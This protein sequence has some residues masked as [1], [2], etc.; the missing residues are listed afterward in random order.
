MKNE[1]I[2]HKRRNFFLCLLWLTFCSFPSPLFAAGS[3]LVGRVTDP[4]GKS[5][6]NA[7]VHVQTE[8]G[9]MI[10][11]MTDNRGG[12][13]IEISGTFQIEIGHE[14]FRTIR[15]SAVSLTGESDDVYQVE[16][17]LRLGEPKDVEKV[18]LQIEEVANLEN[19]GEPTVREGLP[20]SDRL[21]GLRGGVNVTKIAE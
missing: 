15:S 3:V 6:S 12:F 20:K 14:G 8:T 4:Q 19:R 9:R 18:L 11:L 21:F 10:D 7:A 5:I 16:V 1:E 17:P 2:S 13:R